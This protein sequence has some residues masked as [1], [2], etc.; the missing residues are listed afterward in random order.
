[1]SLK[2]TFLVPVVFV[3]CMALLGLMSLVAFS[4]LQETSGQVQ[5]S[6]AASQDDLGPAG[7][8]AAQ[9]AP[10]PLTV[11]SNLVPRP[12]GP[13]ECYGDWYPLF[14]ALYCAFNTR[15]G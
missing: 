7:P 6:L 4:G 10:D 2:K 8:I 11:S 15:A 13:P 3:V 9:D 12:M 5:T 14:L 1:M